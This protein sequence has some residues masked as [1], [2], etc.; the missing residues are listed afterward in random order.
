MHFLQERVTRKTQLRNQNRLIVIAAATAI[1][2]LLLRV[3][4]F[5]VGRGR[6]HY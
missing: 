4:A 2:I 1:A 3:L 6:H 5:V